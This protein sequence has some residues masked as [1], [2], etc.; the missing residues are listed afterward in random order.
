LKLKFEVCYIGP[1]DGVGRFRAILIG[2]AGQRMELHGLN[3]E[4]IREFQNRD[5]L[6]QPH[7][8]DTAFFV[9]AVRSSKEEKP[10]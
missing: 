10:K 8:A 3:A 6:G 7:P 4:Q 5:S 1:G 9:E 2:E